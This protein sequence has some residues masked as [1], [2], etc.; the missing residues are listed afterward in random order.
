MVEQTSHLVITEYYVNK[1]MLI[2]ILDID[3]CASEPC[4]NGGTCHDAENQYSCTCKDGYADANCQ[5]GMYNTSIADIDIL[6]TY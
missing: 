6:Y 1:L 2:S 4:Q 5:T 3:E